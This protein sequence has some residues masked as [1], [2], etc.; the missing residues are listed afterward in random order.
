MI[1][2]DEIEPLA[3][4]LGGYRAVVCKSQIGRGVIAMREVPADLSELARIESSAAAEA[5][6]QP[7]VGHE[8]RGGVEIG[9]GEASSGEPEH[10]L[11][12]QGDGYDR[13]PSSR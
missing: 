11:V 6:Q 8:F 3:G 5:G 4:E 13:A 1:A 2:V 12:A 9:S 10:D 7:P